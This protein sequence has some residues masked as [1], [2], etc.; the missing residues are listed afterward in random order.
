LQGLNALLAS[1]GCAGLAT[2]VANLRAINVT[3]HVTQNEAVT[4]TGKSRNSAID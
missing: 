3:P 4:K 2:S 1:F